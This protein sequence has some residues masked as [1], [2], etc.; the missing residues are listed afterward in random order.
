MRDL[1]PELV[2]RFAA[3]TGDAHAITEPAGIA[4][5]LVETRGLYHGTSPLVLR[6]ANV[7]EVSAILTL[8]T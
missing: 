1:S 2:A 3:I 4:P 8:A 5:Y 6:P 7:D